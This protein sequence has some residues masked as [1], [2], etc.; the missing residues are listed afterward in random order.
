VE[1]AI[2]IGFDRHFGVKPEQSL[3]G[4][5]E[6]EWAEVF[7][8]LRE[9]LPNRDFQCP[10]GADYGKRFPTIK[11]SLTSYSKPWRGM[12]YACGKASARTNR[13]TWP[14][15]AVRQT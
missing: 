7:V 4:L 10:V 5:D 3:V 2:G 15:F 12:E 1:V 13:T 9:R 6:L 11:D 8:C 14:V